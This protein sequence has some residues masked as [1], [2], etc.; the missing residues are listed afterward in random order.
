MPGAGK[1]MLAA[2]TI[3]HLSKTIR[4][5]SAGLAYV[6]CNYKTQTSQSAAS[7]LA[8]ILKQLVQDQPTIPDRVW[9]IYREHYPRGTNMSF[10]D[11]VEALT[12][13]CRMYPTV[14][15][16]VDALDEC[17]GR[18]DETR[19]RLLTAIF[20][21]QRSLD[22]RLM[23]TSRPIP[24]IVDIFHDF[25][26]IEIR[27]TPEDVEQFVTDQMSRLPRCV[28]DNE[29]LKAL[30]QKKVVEAADGM[31]VAMIGVH[32]PLTNR[33]FQLAR[34]YLDS[35]QDTTT[36]KQVKNVLART[37][38][39]TRGK[40]VEQV[41]DQAYGEALLRIEA[42][43]PMKSAL[44]RRTLSWITAARRPLSVSELCTFLALEPDEDD[45]ENIE[46]VDYENVPAIEDIMSVCA[47]LLVVDTE[48]DIARLVHHT[49]QEYF[50]RKLKLWAPNAQKDITLCCLMHLISLS[51]AGDLLEAEFRSSIS[52]YAVQNWGS[53]AQSCELDPVVTR[54]AFRFLK[55]DYVPYPFPAAVLDGN[56]EPDI[57]FGSG[58][59]LLSVYGLHVWLSKLLDTRES[60]TAT[61]N[62]LDM[63]RHT[64][65]AW[66]AALGNVD[67]VRVLLRRPELVVNTICGN[68]GTALTVACSYR[69]VSVAEM[70]LEQDGVDVNVEDDQ[71]RSV[72]WYAA[73]F[74]SKAMI[75]ALLQRKVKH[76]PVLWR[77]IPIFSSPMIRAVMGG[78]EEVVRL[79]FN[80]H[81]EAYARDEIG[82]I[83]I[84]CALL[85]N[86]EKIAQFL[87]ANGCKPQE[88]TATRF[89]QSTSGRSA[90]E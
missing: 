45:L 43:S 49:A 40:N 18:N 62:Q 22:V 78:H 27:A 53:H 39:S 86:Q 19:S 32:H 59:H 81:R 36:I 84:E 66:A 16:V 67:V 80:N 71:G 83:A 46:D 33:R 25:P 31:L 73:E 11:C 8:A 90:S 48:A 87:I 28:R 61:I 34:L 70:L 3:D 4:S 55:L 74:G 14:Y 56:R 12:S 77:G 50:Q 64:A 10:D 23:V 15:I 60:W 82:S 65:L 72:L 58:I 42:Q 54:L 38:E 89:S 79:L 88:T 57:I 76:T 5:R 47:G 29:D 44:A 37:F 52:D 68:R 75:S 2:M 20:D 51:E 30:V 17:S 26:T 63:E 9:N 13:V 69:R 85:A 35:L 1:T 24:D 7:L 41:Y 21:L 6:F